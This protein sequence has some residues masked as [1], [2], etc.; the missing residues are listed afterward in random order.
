[1]SSTLIPRTTSE[2]RKN[3]G[4]MGS[5]AGLRVPHQMGDESRGSQPNPGS[6]ATGA[7]HESRSDCPDSQESE[8]EAGPRS[9]FRIN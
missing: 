4:F 3:L 9:A 5:S 7:L 6:L 2:P 1:M 8:H